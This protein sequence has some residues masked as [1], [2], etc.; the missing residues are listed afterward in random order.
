MSQSRVRSALTIPALILGIPW[1]LA[2]VSLIA[3]AAALQGVVY[4]MSSIQNAVANWLT[5]P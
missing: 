1:N 4:V 2:I 5:E 3:V